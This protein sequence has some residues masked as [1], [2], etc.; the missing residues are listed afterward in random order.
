MICQCFSVSLGIFISQA[1]MQ[2]I[3]LVPLERIDQ[4]TANVDLVRFPL[5]AFGNLFGEALDPG[6]VQV[7]FL[8]S[9]TRKLAGTA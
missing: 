3:P 9:D 1:L 6:L 5:F 7:A 8:V 2:G 4:K